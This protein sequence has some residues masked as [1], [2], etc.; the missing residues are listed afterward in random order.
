MKLGGNMIISMK[1][2]L[3]LVGISI[4]MFCAVFVCSLFLN[5]NLDLTSIADMI[6]DPQ[7]Q[8]LYDAQVMSGKIISGVSGG[9][10]VLTSVVLLCFYIKHYIHSHRQELGIMKALGYNNWQ[11]AK[12]FRVF[13]MSVFLGAM[14]GYIT[15]W[16]MMPL[17]YATQNEAGLLP[18]VMIRFHMV[19]PVLLIL[20]PAVFFAI[21]A[22][23][24][25][26]FQVSQPVM[27]LL[28]NLDSFKFKL[29]KTKRMMQKQTSFLVELQK[30]TI[31]SKKSLIFF[32]VFAPF[33]FSSM[34][35]MT[36]SMGDIASEVFAI[37]I[38]V[39]GVIL[40]C[41]TLFL[42][43]S[44]LIEGNR[45][46]ISMMRVFGYDFQACKKAILS[47]Y[48]PFAYLGFVIG[49]IYQYGLISM[50]I[51]VVFQDVGIVVKYE[52]SWPAFFIVLVAFAILYELLITFYARQI[53]NISLK[54]VM[55][56]SA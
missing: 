8:Q 10:L 40:S 53:K 31:N 50:M 44:T 42:S 7:S 33:C 3:K 54:E 19:L 30:G 35:Q 2:A 16:L 43:L 22:V 18:E 28:R 49:T 5:Y 36:C 14:L 38:F 41:T 37:M 24:Y 34:M 56:Q 25:A 17:F 1:D 29:P 6:Q 48:R 27:D 13:G 15:S 11:I 12:G 45:K 39:I 46:Q 26:S 52:F 23:L 21:L 4:M 20:C 55:M 47:G 9:C 32:V 51:N